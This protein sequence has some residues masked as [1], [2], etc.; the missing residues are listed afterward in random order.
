MTS[1]R[2]GQQTVRARQF[3]ADVPTVPIDKLVLAKRVVGG[4]VLLPES[5][6]IIVKLNHIFL[7]FIWKTR[8]C[9][10]GPARC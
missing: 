2:A 9:A 6:I 7:D 1:Y 10:S 8:D 5:E 3:R 4:F